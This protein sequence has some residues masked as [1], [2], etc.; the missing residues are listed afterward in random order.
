[1]KTI[2]YI[3]DPMCGWCYGATESIGRLQTLAATGKI[4]LEFHP[5]GMMPRRDIDVGFRQHIL[6]ADA[7][8]A[9]L[10]GAHFGAAY[11]QR[12]ASSQPLI[13]D[14]MI[15]AAAIMAADD[16]GKSAFD[17]LKHLQQAHYQSGLDIS[18]PDQLQQL[19]LEAGLSGPD[20]K[21]AIQ[22]A[23]QQLPGVL[24]KTRQLMSRHQV[25]GFPTLLLE[26]TE[27][28]QTL[29]HQGY[30]ADPDGWQDFLEP[31]LLQNPEVVEVTVCR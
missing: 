14:S 15:T 22:R 26:A 8:I 18:D 5:G 21:Q 29:P 12:V 7:H 31:L 9:A 2:H 11:Q 20:W 25:R 1:M 27:G 30:Y 17:M 13:M 24:T 23:E 16:L 19:A 10:T 6:A 28:W 3:F 4:H